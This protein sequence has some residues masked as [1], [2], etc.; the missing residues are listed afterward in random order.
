MST[1]NYFDE[2]DVTLQS[3]SADSIVNFYRHKLSE[4]C[5]YNNIF[6]LNGRLGTDKTL[7]KTTY[8]DRSTIDY[9]IASVYNFPFIHSFEVFD[10]ESLYSYA[11]CAVMLSI[12]ILSSPMDIGQ[13]HVNNYNRKPRLWNDK[14][15]H[16][17]AENINDN[18]L[19]TIKACLE[20]VT[21]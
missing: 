5:K 8:K 15:Y 6:L 20:N 17:F 3:N 16:L 12:N 14:K 13:P 19:L 10:F 18:E 4:L 9:F 21:Q 11:H 1:L 2:A 7:P